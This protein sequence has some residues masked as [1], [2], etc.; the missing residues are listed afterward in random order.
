MDHGIESGGRAESTDEPSGTVPWGSRT[1]QIVLT[2]TALAPLG[3]PLISPALP[4]FRDVFGITD[5]QASLLV[6]TYFLVGI[7]LSP[8][9]GVLA[10][11][12]GRKRVLVG[13]LLAFGVLGGAMALA[14]TFEALLALRVA[15]GTAAAAIFITTVT[16]VGDAFDGVQRNAVLGANVA[17][18]SATA[19]LFPVLGG[20]LAGIAWNAPF[21]AYLAAIPIAAFAQAALDEPQRVDDRDGVSYLVD[22]ARAVLTPALAALFAVAF[23]T[24]FLLFGVI[25]TAMPFVL[26]AT[27]APVLIGVVILVSETA[28]M[29]VALSSGRLARH[30][31]NEW[32]I[33][34]GFACYAIGFA[35]AWAATGLVGT[36]GAVVAIGVGVGLLMPVVDAAV[37]DRVTTEYLAG[38]MSLRNSTTFLGRTAGPIAFA[39]LAI[40]TGIGYEPLLLASSLVAVVA[41]GV[42]VIAGPVRLARVT[43]R[44]PST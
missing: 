40:S 6:S 23:L 38:A 33:A 29:L 16:I 37:S 8:F 20:F 14:P 24:E 30:L 18:L 35:A 1:V 17:V 12:V 32:V 9:I 28:S 34:T 21:L 3:V 7:V 31:S 39:G 4:V 44:Q 13:G 43:A 22:A 2:S 19:A 42:A 36:M 10:D 11:R 25:F 26:A 15:Q 27:L 41:T 5:A